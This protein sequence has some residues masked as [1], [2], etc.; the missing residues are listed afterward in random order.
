MYEMHFR[1]IDAL[2]TQ[3]ERFLTFLC[4]TLGFVG[5]EQ[6]T[7]SHPM[8]LYLIEPCCVLGGNNTVI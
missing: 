6:L 8:S 7:I 1:P 3:R 2:D 5:A 4:L